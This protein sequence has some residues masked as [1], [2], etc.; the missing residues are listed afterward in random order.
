MLKVKNLL[1]KGEEE[2]KTGQRTESM[3]TLGEAKKIRVF[4]NLVRNPKIRVLAPLSLST[5]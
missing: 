4:N 5:N 1:A 2:H 3:T